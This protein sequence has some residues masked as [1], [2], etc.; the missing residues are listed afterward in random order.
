M[1]EEKEW[2]LKLKRRAEQNSI[3]FEKGEY[4]IQISIYKSHSGTMYEIIWRHDIGAR[5]FS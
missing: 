3:F 1:Q 4:S 2:G 5:K